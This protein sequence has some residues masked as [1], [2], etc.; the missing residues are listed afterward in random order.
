MG[1]MIQAYKLDEASY[2]GER[3]ADF[4]HDVKGNTPLPMGNFL[5]GRKSIT[6]GAEF[7]FQNS[8]ALD[9]RYVAESRGFAGLWLDLKIMAWTLSRLT[10]KGAN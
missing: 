5:S 10:G 3:F 9:L 6:V 7:T 8:W 4:A 2:R 1:T